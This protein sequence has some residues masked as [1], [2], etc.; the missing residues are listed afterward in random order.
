MTLLETEYARRYAHRV[1]PGRDG[2]T[3]SE[4][5]RVI[6]A[7][8][9]V[10]VAAFDRA[11]R[12]LLDP[13]PNPSAS[14]GGAA[15]R[16]QLLAADGDVPG[17]FEAMQ[18]AFA[19]EAAHLTRQH[20]GDTYAA[21]FLPRRGPGGDVDSVVAVA[22]S[23]TEG[24]LVERALAELQRRERRLF[25]SS[26]IGLLYWNEGGAITDAND[27]FLTVVGYTR[28]DLVRGRLDWQAMTP[29]EYWCRDELALRQIRE[30]G[31]CVPFEKEYVRKDG[32]RV[33]VL[34]GG[35]SWEFG[36]TAGVAFVIDISE[37]KRSERSSRETEERL[38]RVVEA[39]PL[40]L[41]S[42]DVNGTFTLSMGRGL[43]G[44]GLEPGQM[45][46]QSVFD[47]C[48][49]A[50]GLAVAVRR[51]LAGEELFEAVEVAGLI[52][53]NLYTP[54]RDE[55]G[56]ISGVLGVAIDVTERR[57]AENEQSKLKAQLLQVQ[58]LESLGLLAGGIAHDF[59]NILMP[60]L[61]ASSMALLTI[62]RENPAYREIEA[63]VAGARRA[64]TLTRQMLA[65]SGKAHVEIRAIDL[66]RHVREIATLLETTVPK[67]VRLRLELAPGLPAIEADAAQIQQV[68][69]NL[70]I[71]G[72][73]AIGDKQGTVL[74][75]TGRQ[76]LDEARIAGLFAADG[77]SP[78][79]YV[80]LEV[81]D[82]GHGM[83]DATKEKIFDPFFTTKFTGRGLGLAA[84][85]GIVRTHKGAIDVHSKFEK[86][87][88][89]KVFLPAA[90]QPA[91][92]ERRRSVLDYR[93][94]G[95]VLVID[96]DAG[97]RTTMRAMLEHFGFSVIVAQDGQAGVEAFAASASEIA[98]VIVDMT[99]PRMNGEETFRAIRDI[100]PAAPVILTSGYNEIEATRRFT[101][102][103]LAGFLEK[104]FAPSDLASKLAAVLGRSVA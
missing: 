23:V 45:V 80:F 32:R 78:G 17:A 90:Q 56:A 1:M 22:T 95:L 36:H 30:R 13:D 10:R 97:V 87:T 47:V 55:A 46:G 9:P 35:S 18:T 100:R 33:E 2:I 64:A 76:Q 70:V 16:S 19:G 68:V 73:E 39:A 26:M 65:Y 66:S 25:D 98:L 101:G 77:L 44:L 96:D 83:D 62:P 41:W 92:S 29:P 21:T 85:L 57:R 86:G 8:A 49:A 61:G 31:A 91:A 53:E 59:N 58:K 88:S 11:G 102:K 42:V 5:L 43:R 69:M 79:V 50:P 7:N 51:C 37:R 71:N 52:F 40:V 72:A 28:E 14:E 75:S 60:I 3:D 4:I 24:T 93:G 6:L 15:A 84:V 74:V 94:K 48:A 82:S 34:L 67:K 38:R 54:M 20:G 81:E 12:F 103:G 99:M 27:A 89:F 104:P 63:V